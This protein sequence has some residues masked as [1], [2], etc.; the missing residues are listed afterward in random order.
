MKEQELKD[1]KADL[2]ML[3]IAKKEAPGYEKRLRKAKGQGKDM[4]QW[5]TDNPPPEN[6]KEYFEKYYGRSAP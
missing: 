2:E 4:K 1:A 3:K 6:L 5:I